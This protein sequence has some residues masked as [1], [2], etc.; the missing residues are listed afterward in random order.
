MFINKKKK[1]GDNWGHLP[2]FFKIPQLVKSLIIKYK[3][4][5]S[6]PIYKKYIFGLIIKNNYHEQ[7]L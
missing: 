1:K 6:I 7:I 4:W 3:I 2:T 5:S